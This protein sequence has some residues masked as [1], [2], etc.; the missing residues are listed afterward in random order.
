MTSEYAAQTW[1]ARAAMQR[2]DPSTRRAL[3]DEVD[4]HLDFNRKVARHDRTLR[5]WFITSSGNDLTSFPWLTSQR[6]WTDCYA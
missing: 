2:L 6:K 1:S 3:R 5:S 4:A